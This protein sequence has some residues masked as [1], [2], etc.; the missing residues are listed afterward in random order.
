[1]ELWSITCSATRSVFWNL[2][3]KKE[4]EMALLSTQRTTIVLEPPNYR[5]YARKQECIQS[6]DPVES[7]DPEVIANY[8]TKFVNIFKASGITPHILHLKV[9]GIVILL[10]K[11]DSER[12]ICNV[13]RLIIKCL[14]P[15]IIVAT[16]MPEKKQR[17]WRLP[18]LISH[19]PHQIG[20]SVHTKESSVYSTSSIYGHN[21]QI[22]RTDFRQC[23]NLPSET[24][25]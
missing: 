18:T 4:L 22:A 12:G 13:T 15:N 16:I 8:P 23:G 20:F 5:A 1:M 6:M 3:A 24:C 14:R 9:G 17:S 25:I 21:Q 7:E 10:M 11:I 19:I 2:M